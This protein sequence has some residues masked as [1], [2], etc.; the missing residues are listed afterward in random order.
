MATI[1]KDGVKFA[2]NFWPFV[3]PQECEGCKFLDYVGE[4]DGQ[5]VDRNICKMPPEFEDEFLFN[6]MDEEKIPPCFKE[7]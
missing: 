3:D 4:V 7:E 2:K 5:E 6:D 1:Y